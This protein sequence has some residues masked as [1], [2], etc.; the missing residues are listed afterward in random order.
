[1]HLNTFAESKYYFSRVSFAK[2]KYIKQTSDFTKK[3]ETKKEKYY[4]DFF[5]RNNLIKSN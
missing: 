5:Q 1:M 3:S 2:K 4:S